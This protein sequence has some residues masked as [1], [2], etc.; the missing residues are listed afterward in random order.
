MKVF[1]S[2]TYSDL[3]EHRAAVNEVLQRMTLRFAAMEFFGSRADEA[4]PACKKE[5]H[6]CDI[7]IGIY[8]WRYGWQPTPSD[9]SI[10]EQEFDYARELQK[11]CLCYVVDE[12]HPWR[13][14][15]IDGGPPAERLRQF[16]LKVS[17][18]VR[19]RFTT[20]DNLAKQ[21][22]ADLAREIVPKLPESSFGGLLRIN[23]DVFSTE[24]QRV[25]S[26]A[27]AQA[28]VES[29]DGVVA[30]RHVVAALVGVPNTARPLVVAF[31]GVPLPQLRSN[32]GTPGVEELFAYDK[33]V[34]SCVLG[35]LERLLPLHSPTERLLAIELA[36]DLLK[37]GTGSSVADFRRAGVDAAAVDRMMKHIRN[38]ASETQLLRAAL[39]ELTDPEVIHLAYISGVSVAE[40]LDSDALRIELLETAGRERRTLVL[41]GELIRRHPRLIDPSLAP[42]AGSGHADSRIAKIST[43]TPNK[44]MQRTAHGKTE[45]RR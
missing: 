41:V 14:I 12:S 8:A 24:V 31:P 10:T 30:T 45:R 3:V 44:R 33:P 29:D 32:L 28:K 4:V 25:L 17:T 36:V 21:A 26:T 27:Y 9:A 38:V 2:S 23:W 13:P 34:S 43:V 1:V 37:H 42:T 39:Q 6:Q 11:P 16:K 40:Q 5:I 15:L 18:L 7:L 22:A 20:P 35:S 19:S